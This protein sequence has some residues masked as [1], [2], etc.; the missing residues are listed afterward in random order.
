MAELAE[1]IL[2][3]IERKYRKRELIFIV[4]ILFLGVMLL[5]L[6]WRHYRPQLVTLTS[7]QQAETPGGVEKTA[8][9]AQVPLTMPQVREAAEEIKAASGRTPDRVEISNGRD[10]GKK[11][12]DILKDTAADFAIVTDPKKPDEKPAVKLDEPVQLNV[13]N[14]KAYPKKLVELS[15]GL[16][17]ADVAYLRRV[18]MPRVPLVMPKGVVGY[19][20]PFIRA[21][22]DTGKVDGGLRLVVPF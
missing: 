13:Y 1:Q 2:A 6:S 12:E 7:Q 16:H 17:G 14:I 15:V 10:F 22:Y 20:G 19:M 5:L 11:V 8:D 18:D 9:A 21:E 3:V 4:V